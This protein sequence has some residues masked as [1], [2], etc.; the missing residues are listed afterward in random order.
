MFYIATVPQ[1]CTDHTNC[2]QAFSLF[3]LRAG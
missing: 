2:S 1:S 3:N